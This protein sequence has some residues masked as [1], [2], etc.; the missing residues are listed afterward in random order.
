[1]DENNEK[2]IDNNII[3]NKSVEETENTNQAEIKNKKLFY[4]RWYVIITIIIIIITTVFN[5]FAT[6]VVV[7]GESMYPNFKDGNIML[8]YRQYDIWRFDVVTINSDDAGIILIKRVIGLPNETI[9]YK[10]NMLF[11]NGEYRTDP[12]A[13]G[14][15]EDFT[16]TLGPNEYFCMGDNRENSNDSRKWGAFNENEIFAKLN[17]KVYPKSN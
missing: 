7:S 5:H 8:A 3:D 4:K 6:I 11:V 16:I 9:E 10:N 14:N 2:H 12:Y 15:T 17:H 13:Y 1:M